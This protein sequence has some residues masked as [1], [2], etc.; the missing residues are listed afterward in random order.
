MSTNTNYTTDDYFR[1]FLVPGMKHCY[2]GVS[3][4][5]SLRAHPNQ[6]LHEQTGAFVFGQPESYELYPPPSLEPSHNAIFG[7]LDL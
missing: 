5:P 1:L 4:L 2:D 7:L 3:Q 6:L